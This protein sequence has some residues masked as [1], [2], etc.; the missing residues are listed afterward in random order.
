MATRAGEAGRDMRRGTAYQ[1]QSGH[2]ITV[3]DIRTQAGR[4]PKLTAG[5]RPCKRN[6]SNCRRVWRTTSLVRPSVVRTAETR[7]ALSLFT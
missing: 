2:E 3:W 1:A 6:V 4:N 5:I 7:I